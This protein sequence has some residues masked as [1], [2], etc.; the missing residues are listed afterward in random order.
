M[1]GRLRFKDVTI[2]LGLVIG[3][4]AGVLFI[5]LLLVIGFVVYKRGVDKKQ[6]ELMADYTSQIQ[7]V[8]APDSTSRRGAGALAVPGQA[9]SVGRAII[10]PLDATT[11]PSSRVL[12]LCSPCARPVLVCLGRRVQMTLQR[13]GLSS[14][15][16]MSANFSSQDLQAQLAIPQT[17]FKNADAT[18][19]NTVME[20]S[21]PGFLQLDYNTDLRVQARLTAGGAGTIFSGVLLKSDAIAMNGAESCAIKEV[22]D[23]P[24]LTEEENADRFVTEISVM[25]SLNFHPNIIKLLGYCDNPRIIVTRLYPTDLYRFL[26]AQEDLTPFEG[27]FLIHLCSGMAAAVAAV[28]SMGIAH[29]DIKTPNYLM[30]EPRPGSP[31]PDP[32][33]GDFGLARTPD[34]S[35]MNSKVKGMSPRYAAPEVFARMHLRFVS[36]TVEDDKMSDMYALGVCLWEATCRLVPWDGVPTDDIELHIRSGARVQ[37]LDVDE[38]EP[39]LVGIISV[40][41]QCLEATPAARPTAIEVNNLFANLIRDLIRASNGQ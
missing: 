34:E 26:H 13:G 36:N 3:V 27:H 11:G 16:L 15:G 9:G 20:V 40:I 12:V 7:Q 39:I 18:M 35:S 1:H 32:I 22:T 38:N 31:F 23:W 33:L 6:K 19:L 2:S 25:W 37:D 4:V 28:H 14:V 41:N 21:L 29:R 17:H 30:Q 5:I 24:G 8:R 10:G